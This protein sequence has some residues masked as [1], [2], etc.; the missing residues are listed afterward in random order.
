MDNQAR[1]FALAALGKN[2]TGGGD[3]PE[4][5]KQVEQNKEDISAI[6]NRVTN[7]GYM[8]IPKTIHC[9][10]GNEF[11]I[12]F[13]N[14]LSRKD[15]FLWIGS[16]DKLTTR[17]YDDYISITPISDGK[18]QIPWQLYDEVHNLYDSGEVDII[19][20]SIIPTNTTTVM[21]IGD[22]TVNDG[23]MINRLSEL[24]TADGANLSLLGTRGGSKHEG[25]SGWT[26]KNF[27]TSATV[28]D[29]SN[30]FYNNGFDFSYYMANQGYDGVQAVVIQLG[31]N[32]IF[33]FNDYYENKKYDSTIVL[34]HFDEMINSILL[35]DDTIKIV[36]N[37]PITP[38]SDG[39]TFTETYGTSQLFWTYNKNIIRFAEELKEH[40]TNNTNVTISA[41]NCILDTKTQIRDG[42]HPTTD[43]YNAL[44]DRLYEVLK[45][46]VSGV[47][48]I[49]PLLDI[50][51]RTLVKHI[52]QSS[53]TTISPT[54]TRELDGSKCYDG[55]YTGSRSVAGSNVVTYTPI[56]SDS[57][58]IILSGGSSSGYGVEFPVPQLEVGKNYTLSYTTDTNNMRVY[59]IK[60]NPDTTFNSNELLSTAVGSFTKTIT[61]QEGY[62][63]SVF[64]STLNKDILSTYTGVSLIES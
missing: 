13:R 40:Y 62:I 55:Q 12:Y 29:I 4:L 1:L 48:V 25:R 36:I 45:S 38:N 8:S 50:S 26:A 43:G 9:K 47:V 30:P 21:V 56:S 28:D 18:H 14:V 15:L 57:F 2:R 53:Q 41:S 3:N 24:Y 33:V 22:S 46:T 51:K 5:E 63:Y 7:K 52:Q 20:T 54:D 61:P 32:D 60:Y 35:Y 16:N 34:N 58:S 59:L 27:C 31:I 39:R 49:I 37:L 64:F 11:K 6:K 44:G 17:Y 10:T 42:V 23:T 19:A